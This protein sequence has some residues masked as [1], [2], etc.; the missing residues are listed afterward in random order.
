[1]IDM[2]ERE[3]LDIMVWDLDSE[4]KDF[5]GATLSWQ[6]F[7]KKTSR[8]SISIPELVEQKSDVLRERYLDW[9]YNLGKT[10]IGSESLL[11]FLAVR[12]GLS[13]WWMMPIAR[14]CNFEQSPH[15]YDA[16]R[17]LALDDWIKG[18]CVN[19]I[20]LVT[21]NKNLPACIRSICAHCDI[22]LEVEVFPA[23]CNKSSSDKIIYKWL[24]L[25]LQGL[26]WL[27]HYTFKR[28]SLR[29]VGLDEWG[30]SKSQVTFFSYLTNLTS[31][32]VS[33]DGYES[34]YW[35]PLINTFR[36]EEINTS[37][38]H[39]F[40]K[41]G[42][43]P[44]A[45]KAADKVRDFNRA[46]VAH[47]QHATLDS[48][49]TFSLLLK[50][51]YEWLRMSQLFKK[52]D[53]RVSG[54]KAKDLH[55]SDLNFWPLF[56]DELRE[57]FYGKIGL[58]NFLHLNLI[59][60]ALERLPKQAFGVYLCENQS[61]EY[62]LINAWKSSKHGHL[63]A[64]PHTTVRFWDLRYFFDSRTYVQESPFSLPMPDTIAYNGP[65][66]KY[67]LEHGGYPANALQEAEALR[68][69]HLVEDEAP[70]KIIKSGLN[71]LV[72]CEYLPRQAKMQMQLLQDA[73]KLFPDKT[74]I[75]VKPHPASNFSLADYPGLDFEVKRDAINKLLNECDIVFSGP[76]TSAA[77]D[78][79]CKGVPVA[80]CLDP[81]SLN[82]SALR[83]IQGVEFVKTPCE[84]AKFVQAICNQ[85]VV[86]EKYIYFTNF[87]TNLSKWKNIL[88]INNS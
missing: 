73:F 34:N 66:M 69:F 51:L 59:E 62:C 63:V 61:W 4:P 84:L 47:Q 44:S 17:L 79:F 9:V 40:V 85:N 39:L 54:V 3:G 28:W 35:G 86:S 52:V 11:D 50:T 42:R 21:S 55:C 60:M 29:G 25:R 77:V 31:S 5:H 18:K 70:E 26:V 43:L 8:N 1:M 58:S 68:Y 36:Q 74:K 22:K 49:I 16:I 83:G 20:K 10:K 12:N 30:N 81:K 24:P 32:K 14:K 71:I 19:T 75:I 23:T 41:S 27:I 88:G 13:Y 46:E 45:K 87:D 76:V 64:V 53:A 82:M 57:S 80:T 37:W 38:L 56:Q 72:V 65:V 78:A 6:R 33:D 2:S 48:F 7:E 67:V 15:I